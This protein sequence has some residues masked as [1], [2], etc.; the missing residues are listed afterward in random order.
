M[1][2]FAKAQK[3]VGL[4]EGGYQDNPTDEGNFYNG[5][6]IGTNWGI[7]APTLASYLNRM[8]T[9]ADMQNLAKS[10]AESI[11]QM[12]YWSKNNFD[13]LSNQSVATMIYDGVV[14]HGSNGMRFLME[15][16]LRHMGKNLPYYQVF[17]I[18]GIKTLNSV[19]QKTLFY[20]IKQA[21]TEKYKSSPKKQFLKGWLA[22]LDRIKFYQPPTGGALALAMS[23]AGLG[24]FLIAL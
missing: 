8:P 11:L 18:Q 14:N 21:R 7:S 3:I 20:A 2:N 6:L 19:N 23:I 10:E 5:V 9:R 4:N 16:A 22:R 15:K 12:F 1:A 17:T 13:L 24:L